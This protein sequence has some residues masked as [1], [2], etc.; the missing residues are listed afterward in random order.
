MS[1]RQ[2]AVAGSRGEGQEQHEA[3]QASQQGCR[4]VAVLLSCLH[5]PTSLPAHTAPLLPARSTGW[6][7]HW[8]EAMANTSSEVLLRDTQML[9]EYA[10][11]TASL[12][13]YMVGAAV[14]C[15]AHLPWRTCLL[16]SSCVADCSLR[17]PPRAPAPFNPHIAICLKPP[18]CPAP[19]PLLSGARRHQLWVLGGCQC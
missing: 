10:N 1:A 15:F 6:L 14:A 5:L 11:S 9:L 12:S 4:H 17:P 16:H 8:G 19:P 13:F 3:T 2:W 7:S 18:P